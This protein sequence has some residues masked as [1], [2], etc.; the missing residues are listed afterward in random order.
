MYQ[1]PAI[2]G[3]ALIRLPFDIFSAAYVMTVVALADA[4]IIHLQEVGPDGRPMVEAGPTGFTTT[5]STSTRPAMGF[6][7]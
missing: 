5:D 2:P 7:P 4:G 6:A 3:V 1:I